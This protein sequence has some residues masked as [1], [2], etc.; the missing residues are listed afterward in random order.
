MRPRYT[1]RMRGERLLAIMLRLEG[2]GRASARSLAKESE[3]S[4]R[5]I[6][7]DIDSLCAS[8]VPIVAETGP[9]GGYSLMPGWRSGLSGLNERIIAQWQERHGVPEPVVAGRGPVLALGGRWGRHPLWIVALGLL[10]SAAIVLGVW[11]Q[12]PD[13][14]LEELMQLDVLS[15][16]AAGQL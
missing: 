5:T 12:R 13:P 3:V 11:L 16:M 15:Q 7:R 10:A 6:Y 1:L 14:V 9:G 4:L 2:K 8:G